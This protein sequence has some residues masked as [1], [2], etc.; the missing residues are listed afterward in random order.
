V[1]NDAL[2]DAIAGAIDFPLQ[3]E[4]R[5]DLAQAIRNEID[6]RITDVLATMLRHRNSQS[7]HGEI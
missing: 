6:R 2:V 5:L 7:D 4:N 3:W 1:S